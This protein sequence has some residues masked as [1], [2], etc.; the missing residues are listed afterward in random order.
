MNV[1]PI[2]MFWLVDDDLSTELLS[3]SQM[4]DV[5]WSPWCVELLFYH[6]RMIKLFAIVN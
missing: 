4:N 5:L 2:L 1:L 6:E 3:T